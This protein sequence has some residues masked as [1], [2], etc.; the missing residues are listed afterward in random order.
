MGIPG[1]QNVRQLFNE[2][3]VYRKAIVGAF[4][5]ISLASMA[6][7]FVAPKYFKSSTTILVDERNIIQP[8]MAGTAVTTNIAEQARIAREVLF[9]RKVLSQVLFHIE[10]VDEKT[11]ALEHEK[12]LEKLIGRTVVTSVGR[13]LIKVEHKSPDAET[14]LS[15]TRK[16][17]E[18][19]MAESLKAKAEESRRAFEFIDNQVKEYHSKLTEVEGRIKEFRSEN[20]DART[21]SQ[22]AVTQRMDSL[23][24]R[25]EQTK[26]EIKETQIKKESLE[27]QLSGEAE[28]TVSLS[29]EGQFRSRIAELKQELDR[30]RLNYH[31]TYPDIV[32]IT[33]QIENLKESIKVEKI[34]RQKDKTEAKKEGRQYVDDSITLSP[35]YQQLRR[36]LSETKTLIDTLKA[37]LR[38]TNAL[39]KV[40]EERSRRIHGGEA[41]MAELTRDYQV[42]RDIYQDLLRRREN[43]RVSM[44]MDQQH[45]GLNFK[46]Q[47]PA[48]LP[49]RPNGLRFVHFMVLGLVMGFI[50]PL[51]ILYGIQQIDSRVRMKESITS[52]LKLN[53]IGTIPHLSSPGEI[54]NTLASVKQ[55]TGIVLLTIIVWIV[56]GIMKLNGVV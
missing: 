1:E 38:E 37:R 21:G 19:L 15:V 24:T 39:L 48:S 42:N 54:R 7:S 29:R 12:A 13:N 6:A 8:L 34:R 33:G 36:N 49:L 52:G 5:V 35:L 10:V 16:L 30:L 50:A 55:L 14:A 47:E 51:G 43:A 28:A 17:A 46:I 41:A 18:L 25:I 22:T 26:I 40:D 27:K 20:P 53:V 32:R 44:N 9:S 3:F 11:T 23:L 56:V 4:V 45:H 2:A 31:D